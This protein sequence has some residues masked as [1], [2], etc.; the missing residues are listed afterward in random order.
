[1][2]F[3]T[4]TG[5]ATDEVQV[6]LLILVAQGRVDVPELFDPLVVCLTIHVDCLLF[7]QSDTFSLVLLVLVS[8]GQNH[9]IM[10]VQVLTHVVKVTKRL[11]DAMLDMFDL[12]LALSNQPFKKFLTELFVVVPIDRVPLA[13][14]VDSFLRKVLLWL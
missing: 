5:L 11:L 10:P 12:L 13:Q 4:E 6:N 9:K 2:L 14:V 7:E 3:V 8:L 1:M